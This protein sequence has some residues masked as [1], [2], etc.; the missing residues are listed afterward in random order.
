MPQVIG[1]IGVVVFCNILETRGTS[2][3]NPKFIKPRFGTHF[4]FWRN[5]AAV[6]SDGAH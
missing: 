1:W 3:F 6:R 2:F 4:G 5:I